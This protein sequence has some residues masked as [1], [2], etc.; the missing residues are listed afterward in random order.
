MGKA[1]TA[2]AYRVTASPAAMELFAEL[3]NIFANNPEYTY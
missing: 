3:S 1:Q 2:P